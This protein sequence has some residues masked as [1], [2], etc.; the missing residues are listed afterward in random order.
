MFTT[1]PEI[2][3]VFGVVSS[4][5]W[6]PASV[7]M[8]VLE[9]GGNAFDAAAAAAF[10]LQVIEPH[11]NGPGGDAPI[12]LWNAKAK[13][14]EVVC[15]QGPSPRGATIERYRAL[16]LDLIPGTGLLAAVVPGA[17]GAWLHLIRD[18]GSA[19]LRDVL[20]PAIGYARHGWPVTPNLSDSI[21]AVA[22]LFKQEW[23]S[24]AAIFLRGGSAPEA[25]HAMANPTLADTF[26]RILGEAEHASSDR[27][28]QIEAAHRAYYR[29]FVA[30]A[31]DTFC[32]TQ[33]VLDSS[34]Q[35]HTG[36]LTADDMASWR[37]T[38]E[39]PV[40]YDYHGYLVAKTGPWGQGPVFLQALALLKDFDLASLDPIGGEF[41][42]TVVEALKLAFAD[43]EAWYGD[44][45]FTNVPMAELLSE[46]YNA[47]RRRLIGR[48]ASYDLVPGTVGSRV[49]RLYQG[50]VDKR[51]PRTGIDRGAGEGEPDRAAMARERAQKDLAARGAVSGD[52]VHVDVI[53]RWGNMVAAM[54]SGGWMQSSP[55]IPALGFCLGTRGQMFW[56]ED[57][58]PASLAPGKRPRTTLS[59][60]IALRDG[61]PYLAFGSPGGDSQDQWALTFFLRHAHHK[62][63]LQ[64]AIEGPN[65]Q[66][67]H[68]PDSFYPRKANPG[69]LALEANF[70][71]GTVADLRRRGHKITVAPEWSMGRMCAVGKDAAFLKAAANPRNMQGYAVGR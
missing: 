25:G 3:G 44:P 13:R 7:A 71:R 56:L 20:E 58:Y 63:N 33:H 27:A 34:G 48:D 9:K 62:L 59:P 36:I 18:Y 46:G 60:T 42:H 49:P 31:I 35:R 4:T 11:L 37:A 43:R 70:P 1:R 67:T 38:V 45:N 50:D 40:T 41:V 52:T 65:F 47:P 14:V 54:P 64:E 26:G 66:S 69:A 19:K 61:E 8:A 21:A 28:E 2:K 30:E 6:I 55:V 16:G 15:G 32:R 17:F 10:T 5:H 51:N 29:G 53:D 57:G 68:W 24:S 23:Q 39:A 12:L 22:P